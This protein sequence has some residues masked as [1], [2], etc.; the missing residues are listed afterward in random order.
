M[1]CVRH[2]AAPV[3][4]AAACSACSAC[5]GRAP[6]KHPPA[7]PIASG[8][9]VHVEQVFDG[10]TLLVRL[11]DATRAAVRVLGIDCPE[12]KRNAK[13]ERD[14]REGRAD[15]E[16]QVPLGQ[17]ATNYAR[18]LLDQ[19]AVVVEAR[20]P[21]SATSNDGYGRAL[22]YVRLGDG[23]DFGHLMV[24]AARCE[25]FGWKYPHPRMEAY[26]AAQRP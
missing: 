18:E 6:A 11:P 26:R 14:G 9:Q 16:T 7:P 4:L 21:T 15:C 1:R 25:D 20:D 3:I 19:K 2:I 10:D 13:C 12:S 24:E 23:R 8:T 5:E 22:A 17:A